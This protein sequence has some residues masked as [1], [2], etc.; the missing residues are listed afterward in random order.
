MAMGLG[1]NRS[2]PA[3]FCQL[4]RIYVLTPLG[5]LPGAARAGAAE[6]SG[7]R[8][9][10]SAPRNSRHPAGGF[11]VSCLASIVLG[12]VLAAGADETALGQDALGTGRALDANLAVG[13]RGY[14]TPAETV[15]FRGRNLLITGQVAAGRGFRGTIGYR[16]VDDFRGAIG[17]DDLFRFRAGS[18]FSSPSFVNAGKTLQRLRFGQ[19]IGVVEFRRTGRAAVPRGV[20]PRRQSVGILLGTRLTLDDAALSM[21]LERVLGAS[22][23]PEIVGA[24]MDEEGRELVAHAS[25]LRGLQVVPAQ[26]LGRRM[27]L[28]TYDL[29]RVNREMATG[30]A[31]FRLGNAFQRRFQDLVVPGGPERN[32]DQALGR[33]VHSEGLPDPPGRPNQIRAFRDPGHRRIL[34]RIVDRYTID[35]RLDLKEPQIHARLDEDVDLLRQALVPPSLLP[36][37]AEAAGQPLLDD[38]ARRRIRLLLPA[39][40]H[41]EQLEHLANVD[42]GAFDEL[43]AA[44]EERLAKGEY[45]WAERFFARALRFTPGEPLATAGLAHARIGAG[46]HLSAALVLRG[47]LTERPEMID[48]DYAPRLLPSRVRLNIAIRTVRQRMAAAERDRTLYGFLLA[49]LGRHL[50]RRGLIAEGLSAMAEETPDDPLLPVLR[51]I[52]LG[53][54][55]DP[56]PE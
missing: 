6:P 48:V 54:P 39:L 8:P 44:G 29:A 38:T 1:V 12:G 52:W 37:A 16:A 27:G 50:D 13:S 3:L 18:A 20:E 30:R 21:S 40:R 2:W 55:Q 15:D 9:L 26:S 24:L 19:H 32:P 34:Q 28:T 46:L 33:N 35:Q 42:E 31:D 23:E 4:L 53:G 7:L 36:E 25:S 41:G 17:S 11:S 56:S 10:G 43:T 14:N 47:L 22:A 51:E 49:Y 5:V 45:F